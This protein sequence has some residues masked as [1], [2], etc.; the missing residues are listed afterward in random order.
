MESS[1]DLRSIRNTLIIYVVIFVLKLAVYFVSGVIALLAEALHTL[2]DILIAIF[3][4]V[5][6]VYSRRRADQLHMFGYGRAQ[7]VAALVAAT[8]FISFTSLELYRESLPRL[9]EHHETNYQNLGLVVGVLVFSMLIAAIPL[10]QLLRQ[11]TRGAAAK[12]QFMELINDQMGLLAALLGTLGVAAGWYLA[13][14]LAAL[15]V[16]TII[17]INAVGLFRENLS[18]LIG[19][20]PSPTYVQEVER[21]ALSVPGVRSV[22]K[23]RA[24]VIG[25][26]A[27]HTMLHIRVAP[28]TTAVEANRIAEAVEAHLYNGVNPEFC[29][30]HVDPDLPPPP[31]ET[32]QQG[33]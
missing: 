27:I 1:S 14:P 6:L 22:H 30:V 16:A 8:I 15:A 32:P 3:L 18:L 19:R 21:I 7:N 28:E 33:P 2:A 23:V 13:D 5:A 10:V 11:K 24:E 17:A 25:P 20:A 4:L 26:D 31:A 12:A 29:V 9:F